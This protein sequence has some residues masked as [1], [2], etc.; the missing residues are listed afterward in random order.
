MNIK[1]ILIRCPHCRDSYEID[2][3]GKKSIRD[4]LIDYAVCTHCLEPRNKGMTR[5]PDSCLECNV[6]FS[7]TRGKPIRGYCARHYKRLNGMGII[8]YVYNKN[9]KTN[10]GGGDTLRVQHQV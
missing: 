1:K 8:N 9:D 5:S 3:S 7:K 4:D 10:T 6:P 2:Y